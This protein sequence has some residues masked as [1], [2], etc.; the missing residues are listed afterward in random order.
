MYLKTRNSP[1]LVGNL[2]ENFI[3]E[4]ITSLLLKHMGQ[5]IPSCYLLGIKEEIAPSS[6]PAELEEI[7]KSYIGGLIEFLIPQEAVWVTP[8]AIFRKVK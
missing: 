3:R 1:L 6:L 8:V 2:K 5:G 4:N 7:V